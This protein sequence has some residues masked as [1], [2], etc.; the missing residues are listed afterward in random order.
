MSYSA[1]HSRVSVPG[2]TGVVVGYG[3]INGC[4]SFMS[5]YTS[6]SFIANSSS[7]AAV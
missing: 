7:I 5:E 6:V 4:S 3:K 2:Y 1:N